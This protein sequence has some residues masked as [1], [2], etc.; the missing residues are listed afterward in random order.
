MKN[1]PHLPSLIDPHQSLSPGLYASE[2]GQGLAL[3]LFAYVAGNVVRSTNMAYYQQIFPRYWGGQEVTLD[4]FRE[5]YSLRVNQLDVDPGA[6]TAAYVGSYGNLYT[7]GAS[8]V[9]VG[10]V[11]VGY[12]SYKALVYKV[13]PRVEIWPTQMDI[14]DELLKKYP[15]ELDASCLVV[16]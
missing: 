5:K 7:D 15:W 10:R 13:F 16:E 1:G 4:Q 9:W 8:V 6:Q 12:R 14:I 3:L 2:D 11:L